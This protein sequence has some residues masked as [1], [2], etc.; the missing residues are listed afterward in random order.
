[1][2]DHL[3][4]PAQ[5]L[6]DEFDYGESV[7]YGIANVL[8]HLSCDF[9]V[10]CEGEGESMVGVPVATLLELATELTAPTLLERALDGDRAAALQFL[11]EVGFVDANGQLRSPYRPEDLNND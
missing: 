2:T 7:R 3:T 4:P 11:Q 6:I 8:R 9:C 10:Y 1:M 5:R